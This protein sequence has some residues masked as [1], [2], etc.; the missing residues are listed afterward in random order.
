MHA[1][2]GRIG[3]DRDLDSG[4]LER[5]ELTLDERLAEDGKPPNVVGH[6]ARA[7]GAAG[8][9]DRTAD[10]PFGKIAENEVVDVLAER[11]R[12]SPSEP[13]PRIFASRAYACAQALEPERRAESRVRHGEKRAYAGTP[14]PRMHP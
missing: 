11:Y 14:A 2:P 6:L 4:S 10:R 9:A 8:L 1:G 5:T 3:D 12:R 7:D 13:P